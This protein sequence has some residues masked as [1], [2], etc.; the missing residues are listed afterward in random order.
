MSELDELAALA[1]MA[2]ASGPPVDWSD[3]ARRLGFTPPADYIALIDSYGGGLLDDDLNIF[4][5]GAQMP[6]YDLT[7]EGPSLAD[8]A[9]FHWDQYPDSPKPAA[10]DRPG[11]ELVAWASTPDSEHLYWIVDVSQPSSR[12][13]IALEQAQEHDWEIF[14]TTT[15]GFLLGLLRGTIPSEYLGVYAE[16][17]RHTYEQY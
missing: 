3:V 2:P 7:L 15:V 4:V 14:H 5:P 8:D 17:D 1:H 13:P 12:W 11:V 10:V 9:R 16:R 6:L